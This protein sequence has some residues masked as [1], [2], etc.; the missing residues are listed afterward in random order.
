MRTI[1][2]CALWED[3]LIERSRCITYAYHQGLG[4]LFDIQNISE[5]LHS[6]MSQYFFNLRYPSTYTFYFPE[7]KLIVPLQ[8]FTFQQ[9]PKHTELLNTKLIIKQLI[10]SAYKIHNTWLIPM[11]IGLFP[12]P[13]LLPIL[14]LL[15]PTGPEKELVPKI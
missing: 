2:K 9:Q 1:E 5:V 7:V 8:Y 15:N 4:L 10:E 14:N 3:A 6:F 13:L 11:D 12:L